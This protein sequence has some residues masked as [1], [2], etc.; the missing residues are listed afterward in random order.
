MPILELLAP[1]RSQSNE[2]NEIDARIHEIVKLAKSGDPDGIEIYE[3]HLKPVLDGI[4]EAW[5][6]Y[7]Q[8]WRKHAIRY[9]R[10]HKLGADRFYRAESRIGRGELLDEVEQRFICIYRRS[11]DHFKRVHKQRRRAEA[12][13]QWFYR[14]RLVAEYRASLELA[15]RAEK[16]LH[17][18]Q[19]HRPALRAT[20]PNSV[21]D[22]DRCTLNGVVHPGIHDGKID[23]SL[24]YVAEGVTLT[25]LS[26]SANVGFFAAE[27]QCLGDVVS[28]AQPP[29]L[30]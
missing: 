28:T 26:K 21:I 12:R 24:F 16:K 27:V 15:E 23:V 29:T 4:E 2:D 30:G 18:I 14:Q 19:A 6:Y 22:M 17:D 10:T 9:N 7:V 20:E 8:T 3:R 5:R 1:R 13:Y 25:I 11:E